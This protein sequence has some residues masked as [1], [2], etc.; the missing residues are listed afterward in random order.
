[1]TVLVRHNKSTEPGW[2]SRDSATRAAGRTKDRNFDV[3]PVHSGQTG[4]NTDIPH[5]YN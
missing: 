3:L 2:I 1:M 5:K 4:V